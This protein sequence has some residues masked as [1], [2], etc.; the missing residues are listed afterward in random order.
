V[1][2]D[3]DASAAGTAKRVRIGGNENVKVLFAH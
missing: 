2:D 1:V 3:D